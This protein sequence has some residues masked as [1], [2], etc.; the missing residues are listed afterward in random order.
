MRPHGIF[1]TF[2]HLGSEYEVVWH[3][4]WDLFCFEPCNRKPAMLNY[5]GSKSF[6]SGMS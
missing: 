1:L 5:D 6:F 4:K 3:F 2:C